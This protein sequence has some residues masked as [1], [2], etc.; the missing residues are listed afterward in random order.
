MFRRSLAIRKRH[1]AA[2]VP[3]LMA[4]VM[5]ASIVNA[6]PAAA[7]FAGHNGKI[8]YIHSSNIWTVNPDGSGK[9]KLTVD[10]RNAGPRWSS[11]GGRIAFTRDKNIWVMNA[12]GSAKRQVTSLGRDLQPAWSPDGKQLVFIRLQANGRGDLFRLPSAGGAVTRLTNDAVTTGGNDEP[13]WSP[14]GGTVLFLH[15]QQPGKSGAVIK[16]VMVATK[17][18]QVVPAGVPILPEDRVSDPDF[19]AD[20]L[21]IV[22][23]AKC[24]YVEYCYPGNINAMSANL[25]SPARTE[26]TSISG[27]EGDWDMPLGV[28]A[29]PE[30]VGAL[31]AGFVLEICDGYILGMDQFEFCGIRPG[32]VEGATSPDWQRLP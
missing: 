9:R 17:Q 19:A 13:T 20:G 22:F 5:L 21:G 30:G 15:Y 4:G 24:P 14:R 31:P 7:V 27:V 12:D 1:W 29:S 2:A 16:T 26:L 6:A 10:G 8:A 28:A 3:T 11:D 23:M 32:N 25:V 18:Q